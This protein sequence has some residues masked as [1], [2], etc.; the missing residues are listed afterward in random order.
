LIYFIY[1][2]LILKYSRFPRDNKTYSIDEQFLVGPAFLVSPVLYE[3]KTE[4]DAYFPADIWY[5]YHNGNIEYDNETIGSYKTLHAAYDEIPLHIRSGHIIPTQNPAN[6]TEYA[7]KNPFGLIIALNNDNEATGDLFYDDG[8]SQNI[9][10]NYYFSTFSVRDNKLKMQIEHN[11][12]NKS[13]EMI[14]DKI[15]L[16]S[17]IEFDPSWSFIFNKTTFLLPE[18]I[19][20]KNSNEIVL[21]NLRI[22]MD[23]LFQINWVILPKRIS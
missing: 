8:L 21:S 3:N 23:N 20:I 19:E 16:L 11:D 6:T 12:Y 18:Q 15:R 13:G 5:N 17:K 2:N 14:L 22:S 1:F 7:R 9:N 4:V 10:E